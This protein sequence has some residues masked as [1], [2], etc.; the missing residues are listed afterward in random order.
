MF[1]W[2]CPTGEATSGVGELHSAK[3]PVSTN[4]DTHPFVLLT[5]QLGGGA[6][7]L[8]LRHRRLCRLLGRSHQRLALL[9]GLGLG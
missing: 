9:L 7:H 2:W 4:D 8:A 6:V 1:S 5:V 3:F